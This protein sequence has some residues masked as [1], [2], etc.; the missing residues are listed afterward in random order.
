M[1]N[2]P[3][4][5]FTIQVLEILCDHQNVGWNQTNEFL[6][7]QEAFEKIV[8]LAKELNLLRKNPDNDILIPVV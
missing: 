1:K 3:E 8:S 4:I 2:A 7:T 6:D 5:P